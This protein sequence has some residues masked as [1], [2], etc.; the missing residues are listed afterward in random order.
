MA[1]SRRLRELGASVLNRVEQHLPAGPLVVALS[2]G[3]DSA[4]CAWIAVTKN[5]R[6]RA[7][8]VDH[9]WAES[10]RLEKAA[11]AVSGSLGIELEVARPVLPSGASPEDQA[12]RARY[13]A[14]EGALSAGETLLT[15]HTSDDQAETVLGNLLR[16]AG[17]DGLAG[18]PRRRGRIVRPMLDVSRSE[19]RELAGLLGLPWI[20]DP[21]NLDS[22]LRRNALRRE[23][24]PLL[25]G[26][27]NPR[28]REALVRTA[29]VIAR[30]VEYLERA[31]AAVRIESTES[32]VRL[33]APLLSTLPEPVAARVVRRALRTVYEGH[34]GSGRD[35]AQVL[36]VARSGRPVEIAGGLRVDRQGVWLLLTESR[37]AAPPP[38]VPWPLPGRAVFG[39]WRFE[40]WIE[41]TP[42]TAFPLGHRTEVFDAEAIGSDALIRAVRP[43]DRIAILGG[44]KPVAAA[45]A[46]G[47]VP[48]ASRSTWPVVES[49]GSVLWIPAVR[50]APSG[51]V[52][53]TTRRYLWLSAAREEG[54]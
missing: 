23:L 31:A 22:A 30:E 16:G 29:E 32:G 50:R 26:R 2:G 18:I 12:R 44:T 4:V 33:P 21:T 48:G 43:G 51:W 7:V 40:A 27:F 17:A 37:P 39:A 35:V 6:V 34:P 24:I 11:L 42:P 10:P 49:G 1:G 8:H 54:S 9:G 19:T 20:D 5:P 25:E 3:A 38:A 46:E 45:L 41:Q 53:G 52:N 36:S 14:L 47:G 28:L 15:G 13:R